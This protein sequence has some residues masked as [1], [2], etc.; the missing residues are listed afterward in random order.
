MPKE[1]AFSVT[2]KDC[3]VDTFSAGG[4]GGQNQNRRSTGVRIVHLAS[5]AIGEARDERSQL[6]NKRLA[7]KR[8]AATDVFKLWVRR[9]SGEVTLAQIKVSEEMRPRNIKTEVKVNGLWVERDI[10]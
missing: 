9:R 3:R 5:G 8:M 6:Q 2:L 10:S 1:L 4:K 7:L